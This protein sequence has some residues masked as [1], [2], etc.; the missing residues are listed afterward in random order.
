MNFP[1]FNFIN[2]SEQYLKVPNSF[3]E[4]EQTVNILFV[5]FGNSQ[6][7]SIM[8]CI[9][10]PEEYAKICPCA[11]RC[12]GV[13]YVEQQNIDPSTFEKL[14]ISGGKE[15]PMLWQ[16]VRFIRS[17][18]NPQSPLIVIDELL[19]LIYEHQKTGSFYINPGLHE[20][21]ISKSVEIDAERPIQVRFSTMV[22]GFKYIY[23]NF[24]SMLPGLEQLE[25]GEL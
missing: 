14:I 10:L 21:P 1:F 19:K 20:E 6:I 24:K 25:K 17:P 23:F 12:S 8:E 18:Q 3:S 5:D 11:I 2:F 7:T 15:E 13:A 9:Y 4:S 16:S 22:S